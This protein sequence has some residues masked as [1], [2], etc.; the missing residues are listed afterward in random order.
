MKLEIVR[1]RDYNK[2]TQ[3]SGWVT[4][5]QLDFKNTYKEIFS[6][7]MLIQE[8]NEY[9]VLASNRQGDKY[10]GVQQIFKSNILK[11]S[12][13]EVT[14]MEDVKKTTKHVEKQKAYKSLDVEL[15]KSR[16]N[17]GVN[18][19]DIQKEFNLNYPQLKDIIKN[20]IQKGELKNRKH[21]MGHAIFYTTQEDYE[22]QRRDVYRRLSLVIPQEKFEHPKTIEDVVKGQDNEIDYN[23]LYNGPLTGRFDVNTFIQD[24][25][26]EM[27]YL[28]LKDKYNIAN[29]SVT[30]IKKYL[31]KKGWYEGKMIPKHRHKKAS[32]LLQKHNLTEQ[33]LREV[34]EAFPT[35]EEQAR[36]LGVNASIVS[37]MAKSI[38][39]EKYTKRC[40]LQTNVQV[41][42][43]TV[44]ISKFLKDYYTNSNQ[45]LL[46]KYNI[47]IVTLQNILNELKRQGYVVAKK[48]V[49]DQKETKMVTNPI[50]RE[51]F[52]PQPETKK[53]YINPSQ[54]YFTA[55]I[56]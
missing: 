4:T 48:K 45:T 18:Y 56:N 24:L 34:L 42:L 35:R 2:E 10:D 20:L 9:I 14:L 37:R 3:V 25:N 6:C 40:G 11:R 53:V 38:G 41:I 15:L 33:E 47:S 7:G 39:Q 27:T 5:S 16:Y 23:K 30:K 19:S 36:Y 55:R 52:E 31:I 8:T 44:G 32:N 54:K 1:W 21:Y 12:N 29:G 22:T 28:E 49:H 43:D 51:S 50:T 26:N 17:E 46:K 13:V